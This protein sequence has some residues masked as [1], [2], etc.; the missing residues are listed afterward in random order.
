[1]RGTIIQ[2][3]W[4]GETSL[5]T[6][7]FEQQSDEGLAHRAILGGRNSRYKGTEVK[8]ASECSQNF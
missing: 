4:P 6:A 7:I 1:M 8:S 5:D 3:S 2:R